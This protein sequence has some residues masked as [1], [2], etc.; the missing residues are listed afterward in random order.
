[1]LFLHLLLAA[2][3]AAGE[4]CPS[5]ERLELGSQLCFDSSPAFYY[6]ARSPNNNNNNNRVLI[7]LGEGVDCAVGDV[8]CCE[9]QSLFCSSKA[10]PSQLTAETLFCHSANAGGDTMRKA[11]VP[12]CNA[13]GFVSSLPGVL[14]ELQAVFGMNASTQ[15]VLGG[16]GNAGAGIVQH[17]KWIVDS[18]PLVKF[19]FDSFLDV[20]SDGKQFRSV[21]PSPIPVLFLQSEYDFAQL[22]KVMG[23]GLGNQTELESFLAIETFGEQMRQVLHNLKLFPNLQVSVVSRACG[24]FGYVL[25]TKFHSYT[26]SL[27]GSGVNITVTRSAL[28][29]RDIQHLVWGFIQGTHSPIAVQDTCRAFLCRVDCP[30]SVQYA[31]AIAN[32]DSAGFTAVVLSNLMGMVLAWFAVFACLWRTGELNYQATR[33]PQVETALDSG[34]FDSL[35]ALFDLQLTALPELC[36]QVC[37]IT[38]FAKPNSQ[39]ILTNVSAE[40][41]AGQLH[42]I[43]GVSGGGK[44]TLLELLARSRTSGVCVGEFHCFD[45]A[46]KLEHN[47]YSIGLVKQQD[48]FLEE[49]TVSEHLR[50]LS[51]LKNGSNA[52]AQNQASL[53]QDQFDFM[54]QLGECKISQLSGGERKRLSIASQFVCLPR[55]LLLD[56]PTSGLDANQ[57]F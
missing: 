4:T 26:K 30:E 34:E 43:V 2:W 15:L 25:P 48:M 10:Y 51:C 3:G 44:T 50:Y 47:H 21:F 17:F 39:P 36:V 27:V 46:T 55:I 22:Y 6:Q 24:T 16:T 37:H 52:A 57:A 40:F 53:V 38:Y 14:R 29:F 23:D 7:W 11:F 41:Q 45:K 12:S 54:D 56:E 9:A 8:G 5:L 35:M 32:P 42:A 13:D 20:S 28:P 31:A 49:L 19:V 18:F 1:M 33:P